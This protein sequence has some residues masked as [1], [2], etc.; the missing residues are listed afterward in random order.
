MLVN[1][2]YIP[3]SSGF[4]V[5]SSTFCSFLLSLHTFITNL[6]FP[7]GFSPNVCHC[8]SMMSLITL[9]MYTFY[10]CF[11]L[12]FM[13]C[14]YRLSMQQL[15]IFLHISDILSISVTLHTFTI[16]HPFYSFSVALS[17]LFHTVVYCGLFA[18]PYIS[19]TAMIHLVFAIYCTTVTFTIVSSILSIASSVMHSPFQ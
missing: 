15:L 7:S 19:F 9:G 3:P 11:L 2:G 14:H 16:L 4:S 12:N 1:V 18:S 10:I 17:G 5:F 8:K 6:D 13:K